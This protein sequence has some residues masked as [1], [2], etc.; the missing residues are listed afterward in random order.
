MCIRDR[1]AGQKVRD[2]KDEMVDQAD[3]K[4]KQSD[5]SDG[6]DEA[7]STRTRTFETT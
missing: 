7:S 3:Q 5:R 2:K 4:M 1:Q 6:T